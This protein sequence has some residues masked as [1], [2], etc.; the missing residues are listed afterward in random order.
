MKTREEQIKTLDQLVKDKGEIDLGFTIIKT[1][2]DGFDEK[3]DF[4]KLW[5]CEEY[6][7]AFLETEEESL[8]Q[9][10]DW[11]LNYYQDWVIDL[12]YNKLI[13]NK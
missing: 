12:L 9:V 7:K 11:E 4:V 5:F 3:I 13:N 1:N 8:E 6:Q 2:D 10:N